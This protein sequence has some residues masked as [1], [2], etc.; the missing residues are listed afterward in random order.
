MVIDES[1][2]KFPTYQ[3]SADLGPKAQLLC[4]VVMVVAH[5]VTFSEKLTASLSGRK[6]SKI[7]ALSLVY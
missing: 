6:H 7:M 5:T 3:V 1:L 4:G 2:R